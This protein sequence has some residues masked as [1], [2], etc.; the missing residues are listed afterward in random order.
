[1]EAQIEEHAHASAAAHQKKHSA[2]KQSS[3]A[4]RIACKWSHCKGQNIGRK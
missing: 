1:M 4:G 2:W 3:T